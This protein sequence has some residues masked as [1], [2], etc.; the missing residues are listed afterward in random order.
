MIY[1]IIII[2]AIALFVFFIGLR[3]YNENESNSAKTVTKNETIDFPKNSNSKAEKI[4]IN[5]DA[6]SLPGEK[7]IK[8]L[9]NDLQFDVTQN[10]GTERAFENEYWNNYEKGR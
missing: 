1:Y 8:T 5:P 7:E 3:I 9:L 2:F 6:Y 10:C 4:I